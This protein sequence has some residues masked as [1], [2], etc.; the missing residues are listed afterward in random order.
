[1][2]K[3]STAAAITAA[4][5]LGAGAGKLSGS[6]LRGT[7]YVRFAQQLP[8]GGTRDLGRTGCYELGEKVK[9]TVEACSR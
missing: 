4:L 7:V 9:A 5:V 3:A 8:D 2:K 1:V 6:E